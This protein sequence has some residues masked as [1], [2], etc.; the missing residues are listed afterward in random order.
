MPLW[1]KKE[2]YDLC[3]RH[4]IIIFEDDPY[5]FLQ[6][7]IPGHKGEDPS[8]SE[9]LSALAPSYVTIDTDGRVLGLQTFTKLF[10]PGCRMG[11]IVGQPDFIS[12]L[13]LTTDG[14]TSNPS[15]FAEAALSQVIIRE[16]GGAPGF[17]R[18]IA[19]LRAHYRTRR[20][21][22]CEILAEGRDL[23]NK[24]AGE[25]VSDTAQDSKPAPN[26]RKRLRSYEP[27]EHQNGHSKK[28]KT[29]MYDFV[30]PAGGMYV[31]VDLHLK[32][33]PLAQPPHRLGQKDINLRLWNYLLSE[34]KIITIPGNFFGATAEITSADNFMRLTFV[35]VPP[36]ELRLVARLFA[37]GVKEFWEG[38]GWDLPD[39]GVTSM[40][41]GRT[42]V[43][44][45]AQNGDELIKLY[46]HHAH[47][48]KGN[49]GLAL[50]R[51]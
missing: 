44:Y 37:Q 10:A 3:K 26:K 19:G 23:A 9:L 27:D 6:Y 35:A 21:A 24:S 28:W 43:D 39:T 29:R 51:G 31:W 47:K 16:W 20:D 22:F 13:T 30:V 46:F 2:I 18:W 33:H 41:V 17:T 5:W 36:E 40:T 49:L 1:R 25:G 4:D 38:S 12:K 7:S 45:M 15:G 11:W 42:N 48:G 14:T 32:S 50:G 34:H 8:T